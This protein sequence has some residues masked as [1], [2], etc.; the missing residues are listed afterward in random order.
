MHQHFSSSNHL[1]HLKSVRTLEILSDK[2]IHNSWSSFFFFPLMM[3]NLLIF[4]L[5]VSHENH[6]KK[7]LKNCIYITCKFITGVAAIIRSKLLMLIILCFQIQ[8]MQ[9]PKAIWCLMNHGP[10]CD[11]LRIHVCL[12]AKEDSCRNFRE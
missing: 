12:W 3:S 8:I 2:D 4:F 9:G 1:V 5:S 7:S 10:A 11:S 6:S